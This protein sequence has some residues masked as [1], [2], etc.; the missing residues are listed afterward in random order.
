MNRN[1]SVVS[2]WLVVLSAILTLFTVCLITSIQAAEEMTVYENKKRTGDYDMMKKEHVIRFLVPYSKTYY[3]L[4][5]GEQKG[6]TYEFIKLFEQA[7][8]AREKKR[9]VK[10]KAVIIPT[11]RDRLF[12]DLAQGLGDVAAGNLTNTAQRRKLADFADPFYVDAKEIIVSSK[13]HKEMKSL[14]DLS[15]KKVYVRK[16]SSYY[17]SLLTANSALRK[18]AKKAIIIKEAD[19]YLEDEDL[20]EMVNAQILPMIVVDN[21]KA[22]FWAQVF[23]DIVLH[24]SLA[25]REGGEIGWAIR[26]NSPQL[27]QVINDFVKKNKEG[28]LHFNMFV[29]RYMKDAGYMKNNVSEKERAKFK[30]LVALFN[31]YADKYSFDW[32]MLAA[33][34]YQESGLDQSKKSNVGA[35]GIMQVMPATAKDP[36]VAVP[37]IQLLENNIHA[38]SKYLRFITD[39]YFMDQ[40]ID[41]LNRHLFAFSAYN[42]GPAR[43]KKL[44][45]E[46]KA[47]G[48]DPNLW[49][50][51]VEVIAAKRIGRETVQYVGNI[52]KYYIAYRLISETKKIKW[53]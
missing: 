7:I 35:I 50:N 14:E 25:L 10:I 42:A 31:K 44:R 37:D 29:K 28:S 33:L 15:G 12:Q 40:G 8:N 3:Y 47:N 52:Y 24:D 20:L 1:K 46:A 23:P 38:G 19:A 27:K 49:F 9:H 21:H 26:K 5:K 41:T 30:N 11:P 34:S 13:E 45:E 22:A 6:L 53:N 32:L 17:Q 51:N 16:S 18:E 48:L 39:R 2:R 36:N 4:D 43:V